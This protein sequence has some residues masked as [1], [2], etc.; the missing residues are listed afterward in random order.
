M[1]RIFWGRVSIEGA[2]AL[3]YYHK[4]GGVQAIVRRLKYNGRKDLG[5]HLGKLMGKEILSAPWFGDLQAVI[6]VPLHA[7]RLRS[8]GFNQSEVF[9]EGISAATGIPLNTNALL[10]TEATPTQ[11]RKSRFRRW[12]NVKNAFEVK[13]E[14][15]D[16]ASSLLLVD[17]VLTTGSTLEACASQLLAVKGV[18]I[19]I[20]TIGFTP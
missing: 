11:T 9:A 8:R 15:L 4:G 14:M 12:E 17:D 19:W 2:T 3:Y 20:A 13:E 6:P 5:R 7:K 16:G 1:N 10:R 18:R